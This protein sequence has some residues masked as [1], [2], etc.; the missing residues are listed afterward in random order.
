MIHECKT[1]AVFVFAIEKP[2]Q[3]KINK[4]I[5]AQKYKRIEG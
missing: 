1:P 5:S 2:K 4:K 3:F